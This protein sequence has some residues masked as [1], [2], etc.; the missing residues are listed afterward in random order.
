MGQRFCGQEIS[1]FPCV[2]LI[3]A[4]PGADAQL[5]QMNGSTKGADST[6]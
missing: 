2:W 5:C 6:S 1:C 3:T 4:D